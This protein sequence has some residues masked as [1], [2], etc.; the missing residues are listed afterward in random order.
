MLVKGTK[1]ENVEF[2][3]DEREAKRIAIDVI[4][5]IYGIKSDWFVKNGDLMQYENSY[6]GSGWDEKIREAT[7]DDIWGCFIIDKIRK[8]YKE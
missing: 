5:K 1:T 3:I 6:H 4:C 7:P 8:E 2:K